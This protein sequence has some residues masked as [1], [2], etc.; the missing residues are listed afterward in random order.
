MLDIK[1]IRENPE[2]VKKTIA[3]KRVDL[4]L[5]QLLELDQRRRALLNETET[6]QAT[7]N[8]VSKEIPK[9]SGTEKETKILEMKEVDSRQSE[10]KTILRDV[11]QQYQALLLLTPNIPSEETPIGPDSTGNVPWSYWAPGIGH[12]DPKE[13][14]K[15]KQIPTHFD[16]EPKDHITLGTEL[17]L[18]DTDAGVKTSG[19]RGYYLKNEAVLINYALF[20]HAIQKL[21]EKGFTLM[22]P[23]TLIREFALVGSGHFPTGKDEVYRI[24][25]SGDVNDGGEVEKDKEALYLAGTSEPS[26]LAYYADTILDEKQ[27]PLRLCGISPCY[28]SEIGSYGKDTRGIYRVHEFMKVEQ[29]VICKADRME[30]DKWHEALREVSEE[31]LQELKL[32]YRVLNICTG[33]MGAGKYKMY[34]IETWM[35]SRND[36]GETHSDSN[37]TDWQARRLNIRYRDGEGKIQYAYTLNNTAVASPRI[38]IAIL[39]NYQQKDGSVLVPE[40]LRKYVGAD[41]I[42]PPVVESKPIPEDYPEKK[43]AAES[44][45]ASSTEAPAPETDEK[46]K[47]EPEAATEATHKK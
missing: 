1:F 34:D 29:V 9:L 44:T 47:S 14:D 20:W 3:D 41:S 27:L 45:R 13:D 30:G 28:R 15:I 33:D 22:I 39:E 36:Y 17:N 8:A 38:L 32:P 19:F 24:A 42:K 6:L 25:N 11:E 26:L 7:K 43:K 5:D 4:D 18:L 23:P 40:V 12:I 21:K 10:L 37:L 35:P 46:P 31:I 16:F 2:V